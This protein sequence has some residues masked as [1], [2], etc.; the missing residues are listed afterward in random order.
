MLFVQLRR[1]QDT[2]AR[3]DGRVAICDLFNIAFYGH[4]LIS[5]CRILIPHRS[6]AMW[7]VE[8]TQSSRIATK[9]I[10]NG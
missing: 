1:G 10:P 8:V 7:F 2:A 5:G 3:C 6:E 4:A 9:V